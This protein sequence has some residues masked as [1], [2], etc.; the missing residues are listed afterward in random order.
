[1]GWWQEGHPAV[2][3]RATAMIT[4]HHTSGRVVV[5]LTVQHVQAWKKGRYKLFD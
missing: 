1:V 5:D 4:P 3:L 2:K